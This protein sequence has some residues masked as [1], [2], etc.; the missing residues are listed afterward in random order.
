MAAFGK[1]RVIEAIIA[2][3]HEELETLISA[4][5]AA[6]E[7]ATHE[8]SRAED[9]HDTRGLE[10]SY[11]AGAQSERALELERQLVQLKRMLPPRSFSPTDP[12]VAGA[13]VELE[14]VGRPG[15]KARRTVCLVVPQGGGFSVTIESV[16]VQLLTMG[17]PLGEAIIGRKAGEI[18]EIESPNS[19]SAKGDIEYLI[20]SVS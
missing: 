9:Q 3:T 5:R 14:Q 12:I 7:A 13:L 16:S 15:H 11:L 20:L 1:A 10:A 17:S 18:V 19:G 6:H 8:E 2:R 4:A